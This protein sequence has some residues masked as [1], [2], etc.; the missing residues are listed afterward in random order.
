MLTVGVTTVMFS[1]QLHT[2]IWSVEATS[3]VYL[4]G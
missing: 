3:A 4:Y 1:L 2:G